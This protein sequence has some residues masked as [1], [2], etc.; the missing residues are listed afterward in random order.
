V[1]LRHGDFGADLLAVIHSDSGFTDE[2]LA[3]S[4]V[5]LMLSGGA[6]LE[7]YAVRKASSVLEALAKRM[8]SVAHRK[9][10]DQ[11]ADITT[12]QVNIGDTLLILPHE[13]CPV[14]GTVLE[15]SGTMDESYLTANL[16]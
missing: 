14:D 3:G 13:I 5:V 9:S 7:L 1:K 11:L 15:G 2:Y 16:I 4:L 12:E 6:V 8:P 10:G